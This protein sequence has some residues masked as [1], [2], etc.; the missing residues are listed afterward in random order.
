MI[1]FCLK[2]AL[3]FVTME[4]STSFKKNKIML[5]IMGINTFSLRTD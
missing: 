3:L 1:L 2:I 5:C 4:F